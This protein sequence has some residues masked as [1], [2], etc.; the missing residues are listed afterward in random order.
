L[1]GLNLHISPD[2][3]QAEV[4][5]TGYRGQKAYSVIRQTKK[6]EARKHFV[7]RSFIIFNNIN[8]VLKSRG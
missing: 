7:M 1:Y 4:I 3:T 5:T 2:R 8:R 6:Q